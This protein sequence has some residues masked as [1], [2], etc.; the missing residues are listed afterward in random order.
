M[1]LIASSF[2]L[3]FTSHNQNL[4]FKVTIYVLLSQ[5]I[6]NIDIQNAKN[7]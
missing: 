7:I 5:F 1:E 4:N 3:Q 2:V 6:F